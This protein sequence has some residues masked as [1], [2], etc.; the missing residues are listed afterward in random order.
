MTFFIKSFSK[1]YQISFT[2][3]QHIKYFDLKFSI[4]GYIWWL[5]FYCRNPF[6]WALS[7]WAIHGKT[8]WLDKYL[9]NKY[10][11]IFEIH[12]YK[13]Y[14]EKMENP[15]KIWF[16]WGQGK[17]RM[18]EL[19]RSCFNQLKQY[20]DVTLITICNVNNY[21]KINKKVIDKAKEGKISWAYFSDIV[22]VSLLAE[23]GGLW[24]DATVWVPK[25]IPWLK[26]EKFSFYSANE[27]IKY[28]NRSICFWTSIIY[29]WSGWCMYSKKNNY[30]LFT[31]A[32]EL[33]TKIA[34][35]EPCLPDYVMID[36]AIYTALRIMPR[37]N[38]D[39][40][41]ISKFMTPHKNLLATK[42]NLEYHKM[43]YNSIINDNYFFKLSFKAS[44]KRYTNEGKE[45]YYGHL[46][47]HHH[48]H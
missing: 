11:H 19:V 22:R 13:R 15:R 38:N 14:K 48:N 44:W 23:H 1:I 26:L 39:F 25:K 3:F 32:R 42:M 35:E 37:V 2:L 47:D 6:S 21:I 7:K 27:S 12:Q 4:Y 16:F 46:I 24:L 8:E 41:K 5:N 29:N 17:E 36:Y 45:T 31:F 30:P 28:N 43:E 20:E 9:W 10:P 40:R 33:L 34:L 18:P